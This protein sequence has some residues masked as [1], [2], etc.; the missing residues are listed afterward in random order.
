MIHEPVHH[1]TL[2]HDGS[3][4]FAV[5]GIIFF[6]AVALYGA[7]AMISNRKHRIWPLNR[8]SCWLLGTLSAVIA[9]SGPLAQQAHRDFAAHMLVHLLL[10]M[11]A[12]LLLV[13]AAPMTLLLRTL[14]TNA[15]RRLTRVLS[16]SPIHFLIHPIVAA[17]LNA[18]GL[19]VLYKTSLYEAMHQYAVIHWLVHGHLF[20]AGLAFTLSMI[21]IDPV[22]GQTSFLFRAILLTIV[23]TAHNVLAKQLY[24][25]PIAGVSEAQ[26]QQGAQLMFML[27]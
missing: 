12:P 1:S 13:M 26:A 5:T 23:L 6:A 11:L 27:F 9:V 19:W 8:Y 3:M 4:L 20:A 17:L 22:P 24:S 18:G 15:A 10:G 16:L 25:T 7:A 14:P 2:H 21:R